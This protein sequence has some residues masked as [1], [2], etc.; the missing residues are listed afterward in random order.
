[1]KTKSILNLLSACLISVFFNQVSAQIISTDPA[2]YCTVN[3][4]LAP[5][6]TSDYIDNF[7]F[8][9]LSNLGSGCPATAPYYSRWAQTTS[10]F[11]GNSYPMTVQG[12]TG[13]ANGFGVWID[14]N[15]DYDF[16][17]PGE[18]VYFVPTASLIIGAVYSSTIL[19]PP[20]ATPGITRLRVRNN[21]NNSSGVFVQSSACGTLS[22]WTETEDYNI[23]IIGSTA[24]LPPIANFFPS[25]STTASVPADTVWIN[26]PYSLVSTSTSATRSYWDLPGETQLA[27]GYARGNVA[28]TS[29]LY[30]DTAKY[31]QKFK[32]TFNR[33]GFWP[34]RL[35]AINAYKRDSLRDSIVKY[36]WVDTPNN[37]PKPN[38]FAA[39]T[40][41]GIGDYASLVDI[42]TN[43]PNQWYWT[44]DPACNLCSTPPY[45]N[46]FFAG[47]TD[48]N[49]LFFGGD[50][51]Q[52]SVCLQVWNARGWDTVCKANYLEVLNSI[53]ICSGSGANIS[54]ENKGFMFGPS[55]AGLSYTRSQLTGCTGFLLAP[56]ADS[57]FLFV[58]RIKMLPTD[59]LV[60]RNGTTASSP[61]IAKLGQ[62]NVSLLPN[63]IITNGIR[64]GSRLFVHFM[65][66]SGGIP[67]PYDSAGF[68]IRWDIKP[69]SYPKPV[70]KIVLP[71]TIFSLQ[72]T[73][74]ANASTGTLM[75]FS[76]DTDGNGVYDSTGATA[77]RTFLITTPQFKRICLVTYNCV[78]SD[79]SCK[80]VLLLPTTVKPVVRFEANK[81]QGFNTDT[82]RFTD[83]SLFGPS[84]WKWT[85]TPASAQY[86]LGTTS[87]TRNPI[88]RFTQRT[89]YTVKLVATNLYGTDSV[90][91]IDYINIGAYD[92]PQC[93]TDINLADGSIGISRV[94]LT[95]GIDTAFNAYSPC[96]QLVAG[97]QAANMY[98]G[99]KHY[100]TV[101]RPGTASPMDRRA[102]VDFNMD[103]LFTNDELVMN[104][105][106]AS[107]L[108]K[109]DSIT[110]G[111]NQL[112]GNTRMRVGVTYAGTQLNPSVLFLGVFRDYTINFP[113]DTVKPTISLV[114]LPSLYTEIHKPYVD[115]GVVALDNIEGNISSK[116][117]ILGS[118]DTSRVGPNYL[119]Y[120]VRD[121]YGNISDTLN[122]TVYVILNQTGPT[123][124]LNGPASVYVEVYKSYIEPGFNAKDN[125]GNNI[126]NQVVITSNLDT[127]K[128]GSYSNIYTIVDAFGFIKTVNRAI[129]VGDTTRP[130]F[131][132]PPGNVY[133]Q[134][135][136]A[137]IDL[138]KIVVPQD[139]YWS[140]ANLTVTWTGT[141]DVNNV[142]SYYLLF[143]VRD[144]SGNIG[145]EVVIEVRVKDTK[146]PQITL[147]GSNP[148]LVEIYTGFVDPWVSVTDNYWAA[149]TV[150]VI[151]KGSVNSNALGSYTLW[152]IATDPSGNKD[153]I[154]R[155]V[156]VVDTSI[157][158]VNLLGI[159][160]VNLARWAEYTDAPVQLEDNLNTDLE[161]RG[162]L[163]I[164]NSLPKNAAG[165]YFGDAPGL[166]SV[167]YKV[168]DLS[169]NGSA[170]AKRTINVLHE[171]SGISEVMNIEKLM[172]VYP[173]P[174]SGILFLRLAEIQSQDVQVIVL[175][176]LGK[177]IMHKNIKG[178]N[179]QA[180][181]LDLRN[182][183]KG[184][185]L[186]KVQTGQ[187]T[188]MKKIQIN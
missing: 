41:I 43:G 134:Q 180:E 30:I 14:Y 76:W 33:R 21:W 100:L 118:V 157:P 126:N 106:N 117:E 79:T 188:Y 94:T 18:F 153:S 177:E 170:E 23:T 158:K 59:T 154:S 186:L 110:I 53:N 84:S 25:Q 120:L 27:A 12:N 104:N 3:A 105:M 111:N 47:P 172:S 62:A 101:V 141:V 85:F 90:I 163:V 66:G 161:M 10:V 112:L 91:K 45:F 146:A 81:V 36:I 54:T 28:F 63:S 173:N 35:L 168:K 125:Q 175:D 52:F 17:D 39:R 93:L 29:Q 68:S 57:I 72:P 69:A 4:T 181:E 37:V 147:S 46:N 13:K 70:S 113:M 152:Y 86:L 42:S 185:Y 171:T 2:P 114:S 143:N 88:I 169:G 119:R 49:P 6:G 139:N 182:E 40:K 138:S 67:T 148:F 164:I 74:Y 32:Y 184:F 97:L 99:K 11:P 92:Q 124:T 61:I 122:R 83:K 5:C 129:S 123:L 183:A 159:N 8:A 89:K 71:D 75:Q 24:I 80:N 44:F 65:V 136:G 78:G 128:L 145:N 87:T 56:C 176:M 1:M 160:E 9:T 19:I 135:V 133:V 98:R 103:G 178:D 144:N 165:N 121:M 34:V 64:G 140:A 15:S 130:W 96:Y 167:R 107:T 137:A 132:T 116:L 115:P 102:W 131:I 51:G 26:S 155:E 151:R 162:N 7:T 55:G 187:N 50:P 179:L 108:S 95:G 127:S 38:F 58:D 48:Q 150:S 31:S 60:I 22:D 109:V 156:R 82:F 149:S 16:D 166:Y 73:A 142:G 77:T 20:T 174:A